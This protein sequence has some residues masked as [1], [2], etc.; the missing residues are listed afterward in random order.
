MQFELIIY[1]F[2]NLRFGTFTS[3]LQALVH[4]HLCF[5]EDLATQFTLLGTGILVH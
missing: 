5:D 1:G 3:R 4:F 2:S